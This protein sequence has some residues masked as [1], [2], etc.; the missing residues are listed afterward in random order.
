MQ[1]TAMLLLLGAAAGL[2]SGLIGI[3]GGVVIVPALVFIFGFSQHRAEGTTLAL[4]V[5]PV[6]LLAVLPYF[7]RGFVDIHAASFICLGFLV[8]GLIGGNLATS[9][10]SAALQRI[11]G[12]ALLLIAVRMLVAA[13]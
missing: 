3:G 2:L 6:G 9:F 7:R 4:L 8:G 11:F 10:S 1:E 12:V 13:K 5:P